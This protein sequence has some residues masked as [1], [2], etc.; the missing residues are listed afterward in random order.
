[1]CEVKSWCQVKMLMLVSGM[2]LKSEACSCQR[3]QSRKPK[4]YQ[5]YQSNQVRCA[6]GRE[7]NFLFRVNESLE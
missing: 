5:I 3:V 1:M 6:K 2:L 7:A 4:S